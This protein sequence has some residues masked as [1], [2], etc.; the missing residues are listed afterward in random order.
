MA[1]LTAPA[2]AGVLLSTDFDN[3]DPWPSLA[4]FST[5]SDRLSAS[6]NLRSA[7]TI[8]S[9]DGVASRAVVLTVDA[10]AANGPWN[11]GL[12]SGRLA[13]ANL[14]SHLGR[15]T[16]GFDLR[17][18]LAR[19]V[20]VRL[21]S[22]AS[23]SAASPTGTREA[24]VVPPVAGSY[25]R[26]SL[27]LSSMAPVGPGT[28]DPLAPL[29]Q[30]QFEINRGDGPEDWPA[31]AGLSLS[32]DNLSYTSPAY[33]VSKIG[34]NG[35]SGRSETQAFATI[36]K[37]VDVAS[38]GDVI[39]VMAGTYANATDYRGIRIE[40]AG[41]P[42]RWIV[43]R[44]SPDG[45]PAQIVSG[46]SNWSA[47]RMNHQA[48]FIEIR[49]LAWKGHRS[50]VT[51]AGAVADHDAASPSAAYNGNGIDILG[52]DGTGTQRPHHIRIV[53][54]VIFEHPGGGGGATLADHVT[55][56]GNTI[57]GNCWYMRYAGSG[58]SFRNPV[59]VDGTTSSSPA[60]H[61]MF[62]IGNVVYRNQ[63]YIKWKRP[64]PPARDSY[65]DGN[66]II[67]DHDAATPNTYAGRT[68]VQN[69]L[70]FGNGGS[71][72]HSLKNNHLEIVNNT[73]YYNGQ[74]PGILYGPTSTSYGQ[75]FVQRTTDAIVANNIL[76]AA[77]GNP[78]NSVSN[79]IDRQNVNVV[80]ANNLFYGD[81]GNFIDNSNPNN[82]GNVS[83]RPL[84][85]KPPMLTGSSPTPDD[86][87]DV[88]AFD[89]RLLSG[90]PGLDSGSPSV[91]G[92]PRVDLTGRSR[93]LGFDLDCGA[94]EHDPA[95]QFLLQPADRTVAAG[96]PLLLSA[97]TEDEA[98]SFQWFLNDV[99]LPGETSAF[100]YRAAVSVGDAGIYTVRATNDFGAV[101]SGDAT[102][103]V[104]PEASHLVNLSCRTEL[105]PDGVLITGF[106]LAGAGRKIVL[107]RAIGPT[108]AAFGVG[109]PLADP[110]VSVFHESTAVA[111]N[112]NWSAAT[113]GDA[114]GRTGA[115]ALPAESRDAAV[116]LSL[117]AP[118]A[119]TVHVASA[120]P[121]TGGVVLVETYDADSGTVQRTARLGNVSVRGR[122]GSGE[123][124]LIVGFVLAGRGA[125]PLLVRG[126]GPALA[127]FGVTGPLADPR[128]TVFDGGGRVLFANDDWE[129]G[130]IRAELEFV[131]Q[132]VGAFAFSSG[133]KDASATA[134]FSPGP[135]TVHAAGS[136]P[137]A[138][139]EVLVEIYEAP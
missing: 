133:S 17:T 99:P 66:G 112:D 46:P 90:S 117:G 20:R 105:A 110:K 56:A 113:M 5:D 123:G 134:R 57:F 108:L 63:C 7:G 97:A 77:A 106:T 61:K 88:G 49:G 12:T 137:T 102:V 94:Y 115:F 35:N 28:F 27:D 45:V 9:A 120:V 80:F 58:I 29:V 139:G 68:L 131:R 79:S 135:F 42:A 85:K 3:A 98:P 38:A 119:Y 23:A 109:R 92:A 25:Y 86:N 101:M 138:M 76:W 126:G 84:F 43:L 127:A 21:Q 19:P 15:L 33:Y 13:V 81:G 31:Q 53:D 70:T 16:L 10:T 69:N 40:K 74:T 37:A 73:A 14:E 51:Y 103:A 41:T 129:T 87:A 18:S 116:L 93:P 47:V 136:T 4:A 34:S 75:I 55:W 30:V 48:A 8:D 26:H 24:V 121:G 132:R 32:V 6:A 65:S 128:V 64:G 52:D 39:M 60:V 67:L 118:G 130:G 95:P 83:L 62:I 54:N 91:S 72:I 96:A 124:T 89:F 107:V 11:A 59:D 104:D 22:F 111:A 71:G 114:F 44:S 1:W 36:Q 2:S 50:K 100:L 78:I 82:A 125:R 122:T